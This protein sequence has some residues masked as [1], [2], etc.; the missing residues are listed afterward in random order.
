MKSIVSAIAISLLW[1][2]SA[3]AETIQQFDQSG[4]VQIKSQYSV[5]QTASRLV[6]GIEAKGLKLFTQI[7]H[8]AG[9]KSVGLTIPPTQLILFGNPKVG[10][11]LMQCS[12]SVAIDLPHKALVWEDTSG[13]VW[14]GYNDAQY[15]SQRHNLANCEAVL[16]KVGNVLRS[17]ATEAAQP[18]SSSEK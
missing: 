3:S 6:D 8:A 17:L 5:E 2:F 1:S 4:L 13:Q 9:A 18:L 15:L 12:S 7:D 11:P 16:N 14:V 10:T